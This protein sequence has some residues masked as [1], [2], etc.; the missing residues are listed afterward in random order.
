MYR[1]KY[2]HI[3]RYSREH[4]GDSKKIFE[5]AGLKAP[6]VVRSKPSHYYWTPERIEKELR[7][8]VRECGTTAS[9]K[10]VSEG[11]RSLVDA[12]KRNF[13]TWNAGLREMGFDVA[14]KYRSTED[15]PTKEELREKVLVA[16]AEGAEPTTTAL[17]QAIVGFNTSLKRYFSGI[18]ELRSFCGICSLSE[19]PEEFKSKARARKKY[20]PDL[21]TREGVIREITR[22]WY[23]GAPLNYRA[24]RERRRHLIDSARSV[25]GSWGEAVESAGIEYNVNSES[26]ILSEC[27]TDF[28]NTFA[29]ILTEMGHEFDREAEEVRGKDSEFRLMPD[30]VLSDWRWIDCKLSEWTDVRD[31]L[32]RYH[33]EKPREIIIVYL[34]GSNNR[35]ER[36]QKWKYTHVSVYQYT[37]LL[38][39]DKRTYFEARLREIENRAGENA[40]AV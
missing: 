36:G 31:T 19:R 35:R 29:E 27:G 32:R 38:Q 26:N 39:D 33:E 20:T 23:V 7:V 16:I 11:H 30:F 4:L 18:S 40:V 12:V 15:V 34:R 2:T 21:Q 5:L 24:V 13:G 17:G 37:K 8:A 25:I 14:Y 1:E 22:L 9:N 3:Y 6:E 28:E 10:L